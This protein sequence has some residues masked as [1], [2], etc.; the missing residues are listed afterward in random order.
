MVDRKESIW[1]SDEHV[2]VRTT[3]AVYSDKCMPLRVSLESAANSE[4]NQLF[5]NC[6]AP[7][8]RVLM[9]VE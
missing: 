4:Q 3:M 5:R 9:S 6:F 2:N 1:A 7:Q 8:L